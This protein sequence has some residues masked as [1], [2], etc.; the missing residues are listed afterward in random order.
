MIRWIKQGHEHSKFGS[1]NEKYPSFCSTSTHHGVQQE[2]QC[3]DQLTTIRLEAY[4]EY[5]H[6]EALQPQNEDMM[7]KPATPYLQH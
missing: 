3:S 1:I 4:L 2:R 6:D 5:T 7:G